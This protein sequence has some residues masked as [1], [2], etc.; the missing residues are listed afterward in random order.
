MSF[1][2]NWSERTVYE[3]I[4][5]SKSKPSG[6]RSSGSEKEDEGGEDEWAPGAGLGGG[7]FLFNNSVSSNEGSESL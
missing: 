5:L 7:G 1:G 2:S 6:N 4:I 3:K